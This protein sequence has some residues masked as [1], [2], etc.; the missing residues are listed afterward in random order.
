MDLLK[1][2]LKIVI[3]VVTVALVSVIIGGIFLFSKI[4]SKT[5]VDP[6]AQALEEVKKYT[7]EIGKL[8]DLP[9]NETPTVA[10]VVDSTKLAASPF[11]QKAKNGD[12]V[13]LYPNNLKAILY[14]PELKK[15][16]EVGWPFNTTPATQSAT[17]SATESATPV[18]SKSAKPI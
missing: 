11:F 17:P 14:N 10:T 12:K 16:I 18:A 15:I 3:P 9:V 6:Q 8:M 2:N 13:L 5:P 1:Q 7:G 4:G